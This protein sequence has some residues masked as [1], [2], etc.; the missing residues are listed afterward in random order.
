M[1]NLGQKIEYFRLKK[2]FLQNIFRLVFPNRHFPFESHIKTN[3]LIGL[4]PGLHHPNNLTRII[5]HQRKQSR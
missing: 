4:A 3:H 2:V 5:Q 1:E